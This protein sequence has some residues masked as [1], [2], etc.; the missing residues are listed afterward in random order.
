MVSH[1]TARARPSVAWLPSAIARR[2]KLQTCGGAKVTHTANRAINM[3]RMVVESELTRQY[4]LQHRQN[5][6]DC[7]TACAV[8]QQQNPVRCA[9][10]PLIPVNALGQ[11]KGALVRYL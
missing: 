9:P 8:Q 11:T 4:G 7:V 3:A 5:V 10:S 1:P 2:A 6:P